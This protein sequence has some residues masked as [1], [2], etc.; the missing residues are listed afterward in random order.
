MIRFLVLVVFVLFIA[1]IVIVAVPIVF[2]NTAPWFAPVLCPDGGE[3]AVREIPSQLPS[4]RGGSS[5]PS[6]VLVCVDEDG[7]DSSL[8][9]LGSLLLYTAWLW[10][11]LIPLLMLVAILIRRRRTAKRTLP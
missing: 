5:S 8:G 2:P 1:G 3:V 7:R 6:L 4:S 11:P 10:M 9:M